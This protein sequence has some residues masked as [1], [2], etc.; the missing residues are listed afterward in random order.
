[1][2]CELSPD[3][4]GYRYEKIRF[5]IFTAGIKPLSSVN[6]L[7]IT[8]GSASGKGFPSFVA[9][10]RPSFS[11]KSLMIMEFTATSKRFPTFTTH[12]TL[13]SSKATLVL[14]KCVVTA[15]GFLALSQGVMIFSPLNGYSRLTDF[16]FTV[17]D[18]RDVLS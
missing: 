13:S 1:M 9:I 5:P 2:Q 18:A 14:S 12:K 17:H 4:G 15:N 11:V 16:I 3:N 8:E 7:M 10:I 6:S